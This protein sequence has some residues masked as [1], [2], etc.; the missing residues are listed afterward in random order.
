MVV[1]L[2]RQRGKKDRMLGA[3]EFQ[4]GGFAQLGASTTQSGHLHRYAHLRR[5]REE[6]RELLGAI[7]FVLADLD[8]G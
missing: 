2:Q 7:W 5:A 1:K 6:L 8:L 4:D 3:S